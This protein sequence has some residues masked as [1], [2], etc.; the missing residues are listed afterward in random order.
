MKIFDDVVRTLANVRHVSRLRRCLIS[1]GVLDTLGYNVSMK[2]DTR[3]A[4]RGALTLMKVEKVK[5]L[6]MFIGE[7]VAGGAMKER[8]MCEKYPYVAKKYIKASDRNKG[9]GEVKRGKR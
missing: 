2:N 6:F 4:M 9:L 7:L 3:S 1:L 5:N 8:P